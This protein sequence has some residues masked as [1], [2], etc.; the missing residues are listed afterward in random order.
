MRKG[1]ELLRDTSQLP[2][3]GAAGTS[4]FRKTENSAGVRS[5]DGHQCRQRVSPMTL[6]LKGRGSDWG[7]S[8]SKTLKDL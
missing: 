5:P 4:G 3:K 6:T 8:S 7:R 2:R 1:S